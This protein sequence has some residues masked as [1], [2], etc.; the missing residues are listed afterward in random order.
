MRELAIN[1]G[2]P[3]ID[4]VLPSIR[5]KSGRSLGADELAQLQEVIDS[6]S[7]SFLHGNKTANSRRPLRRCTASRL[8]CRLA[9][10]RRRSTLPLFISI[11]SPAKK[12]SSR[13][14]PI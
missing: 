12:S 10:A 1:G 9:A 5:N 6:G 7:L 2:K 8:L 3:A 11:L 13:R 4:S 14:S